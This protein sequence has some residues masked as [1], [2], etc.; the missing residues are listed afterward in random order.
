[1][2]LADAL[3]KV[4]VGQKE[5][6]EEFPLQVA[7]GASKKAVLQGSMDILLVIYNML[8]RQCSFR[9]ARILKNFISANAC[10]LYILVSLEFV[11][12]SVYLRL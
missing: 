2:K 5:G 8:W 6:M 10:F 4:Y 12:A 11:S 3:T 1:M 7:L 9:H